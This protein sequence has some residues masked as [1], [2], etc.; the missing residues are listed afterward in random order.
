MTNTLAGSHMLLNFK[1]C[2][3]LGGTSSARPVDKCHLLQ[4]KKKKKRENGFSVQHVCMTYSVCLQT[5]NYILFGYLKFVGKSR[6]L[7]VMHTNKARSSGGQSELK[8]SQEA[9]RERG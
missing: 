7:A 9:Y 3:Y 1:L 2:Y 8:S 5:T 4:T 6:I